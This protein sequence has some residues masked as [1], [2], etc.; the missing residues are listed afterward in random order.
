MS[1]LTT[2]T[3][4]AD[5]V[6]AG[7][8]LLVKYNPSA[9]INPV[10]LNQNVFYSGNYLRFNSSVENVNI[11]NLVGAKVKSLNTAQEIS[12]YDIPNGIYIVNYHKDG[13]SLSYKFIR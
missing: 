13:Q 1:T 11:Y 12:L 8:A 6:A 5:I 7:G 10:S 4:I 3:A 2:P 9:G